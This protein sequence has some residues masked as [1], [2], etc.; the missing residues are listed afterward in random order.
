MANSKYKHLFQPIVLGK[1][2]FRNRIFNSP[3]GISEFPIQDCIHYYERKALG[4]AASVCI[5]DACPSL[6]GMSRPSHINLWDESSRL[7]LLDV[8]YAINRHG[9]VSSMEILHSGNCSYYS[10]SQGDQPYGPI[11]DVTRFGQEIHEMPEETILKYIEDFAR[12]AAYAKSCGYGMVTV[13]GG[14]GWLISQFFSKKNN[15]KDKWG[16]SPENRTRLAVAICDRIH[17]ICGKGYPVEMRI[18]GSEVFE[19]GYGVEGGIE[20]ATFLEGHADLIHVSVGS[21][22]VNDV[23]TVTHP[24]MFLDDGVNVQYAAE[25]KKHIKNTPIATVGALSEPELMEE[26]IASGKADVVELARGLICDPDMPIKLQLGKD[27]EVRKCMRCMWCFSHRMKKDKIVCAINPEIGN[28]E[29]SS[30]NS[31]PAAVRKN[32]LVVGGGMAGMQAALTCAERG[33]KVTLCEKNAKLGGALLCE[34]QVPFKEKLGQYIAQQTRLIERNSNIEVRLNTRVTPEVA[35]EIA[36]DVI[37]AALGAQPVKPRIPGIDGANVYGAEEIYY[38]PE[39]AGKKV[40]ILGGGLVGMEL[41][42]FLSMQGRQC[43]ILEMMPDLNDGGNNLQGLSLSIEFKKY[44]VQIS[45][46]TKAI[47]INDKGVIGEFTGA[48]P[49]DNFPIG[50][51]HYYAAAESGTKLFEGDTVV[52]A[53]GQAPLWAETD[54]LRGYAMEFHQIG[55]CVAPKNIWNATN[56]AHFVSKDLGRY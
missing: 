55:D 27:D 14:H 43:T 15:R 46:A 44:G 23:F 36:P 39:K 17:E 13:H 42:V 37:L 53:V 12:A 16:G 3:T 56:S 33:H 18:S 52:Y 34:E 29:D 5:G 11:T 30:Y 54:T 24:S 4:G 8:A 9:A 26:I 1:Q 41:A 2:V 48:K 20:Q 25:I 50:L 28:E 21:H 31:N 22:E 45:P 51:P 7:D 19:G 47:E 38:H 32:V 10:Y 40:I 35:K 49:L 6:D